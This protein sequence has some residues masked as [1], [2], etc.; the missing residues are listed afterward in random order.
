MFLVLT[1]NKESPILINSDEISHIAEGHTYSFVHMK[2]GK[3][4]YVVE[5]VRKIAAMLDGD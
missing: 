4:N 5:R 1:D 2:T 3:V